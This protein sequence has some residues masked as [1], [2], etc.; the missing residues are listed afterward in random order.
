MKG[1][2]RVRLALARIIAPEVFND[3]AGTEVPGLHLTA[4]HL[5]QWKSGRRPD[6]WSNVG[7]REFLTEA[8]RQMTLAE[9]R[10][11]ARRRFGV[12]PSITA[13][14]RYWALLDKVRGTTPEGDQPKPKGRAA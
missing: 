10:D 8:H 11:E 2:L 9:A 3:L 4:A 12:A 6:W 14:Q 1:F 5:P 13:I 7:L